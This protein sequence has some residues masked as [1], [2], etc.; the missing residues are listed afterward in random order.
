MTTQVRSVTVDLNARVAKYKADIKSAG[1]ATD[2]A[3][4][5]IDT[6]VAKVN[7]GFSDLDRQVQAHTKSVRTL[8]TDVD[9]LG[10][11]MGRT[12]SAIDR[13]S[14]RL[15]LLAK[16]LAAVGPAALPIGAVGAAAVAGL[17]SQLGFATVGMGTLVAASQ[18]VGTALEAVNKAALEPTAENLEAAREAMSR[19]GPDAQAFVSRFQELR[20]VL[21]DIRDAAA[22]GW[23]PGL[24]ES[25]DSFERVAP[26]VGEIFQ[27]IGSVGGNLVADAAEAL[28]GPEWGE[29]LDFVAAEAPLALE[30]LGHA[31]G[32]VVTGLADLWMATAPLNSSFSTWILDASEAFA[33]WADGLSQTE[34][35]QEFIAYIR[36]NGPK[37]AE[38]AAAV[39]DALL[40]I[41][42]AAAPL[43]GPVLEAL[44][45]I[46]RAIAA[47]ADSPLGT[48][49]M[50]MVTALSAASLA[51]KAWS[52]TLG[53][54]NAQLAATGLQSTKASRGI[55][56]LSRAGNV[57]ASLLIFGE[58]IDGIRGA[59]V[60]A[61][62]SVDKLTTALMQAGEQDL[63]AELGG[64]I[65]DV[66]NAADP[67]GLEAFNNQVGET[68]R[69]VPLLGDALI[70]FA[71]GLGTTGVQAEK[72]Q[73]ALESLDAALAQ[74]VV[75]EGPEQAIQAF[76]RLAQA[77]DLT[78]AE[79]DQL[80]AQLPGFEAGM[81]AAGASTDDLAGSARNAGRSIRSLTAAV[82]R[83]AAETLNAFDAE[84]RWRD[85]LVQA[86]RQ[87]RRSN[88]GIQGNTRAAVANR[89]AMAGLA[90]AWN[91]Q[92]AAVRN[93]IGRYREAK[94]SFIDV[95]HAMGVP[96]PVA[97]RLARTMLAVPR[98][99]TASAEFDTRRADKKVK[100]YWAELGVLDAYTA[101]PWLNIYT[102]PFDKKRKKATED[103]TIL[104]NLTAEPTVDANTSP[105]NDAISTLKRSL[106]GI[107]DEH[108]WV[109]VHRVEKKAA[110]GP[111]DAGL[112]PLRMPRM[113]GPVSGP[114]GPTDDLVPAMLSDGEYVEPTDVVNYYG[115]SYFD[116]LRLKLVPR[117]EIRGY[118]H[119][120]PV[121]TAPAL[122]QPHLV[123]AVAYATAPVAAPAVFDDSRIV[124]RLDRLERTLGDV[125]KLTAQS[126]QQHA[127]EQR[128]GAS[129]AARNWPRGRG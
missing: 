22:A 69:S 67:S 34:G 68:V 102:P 59:A 29:F 14:G 66:L 79:Q 6:R 8:G 83:N 81:S 42:D 77:E 109:Y 122:V 24:T 12:G 128:R 1:K 126:I 111:V 55:A 85:A 62:P 41:A 87:A 45:G 7:K 112:A 113:A 35:F 88:A 97:R 11:S 64:N 114:G 105:A 65:R 118:A 43:G 82:R 124:G 57:A 18:G 3:F 92:S 98:R 5:R 51:T 53:V 19:I 63:N 27:S 52:G 21:G 100:K 31:V 107:P 78:A 25:L 110:G 93:N 46:V 54:L 90:G 36:E 50:A 49:I 72:A 26:R 2:D 121:S 117:E 74:I 44:T 125:G 80:L 73:Q 39:G 71:P 70:A 16:G 95:A 60:G 76:E 89:D 91:N 23:F 56:A 32:N 33:T 104:G 17:A 48:P 106:T 116:A 103:L 123:P 28:A 84:T 20:P 120:G 61:A 15:G 119:G 129:S 101:N 94:R 99:I 47:I 75:A 40:E 127:E 4:S 108:V 30:Q 58:V 37:V 96:I 9:R 115:R 10:T 38:L 86:T 13:T